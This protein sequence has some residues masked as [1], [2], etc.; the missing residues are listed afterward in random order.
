MARVF[1]L[2]D[3]LIEIHQSLG[4]ERPQSVYLTQLRSMD[5]RQEKYAELTNKLTKD[6][7]EAL[8]LDASATDSAI[9]NMEEFA[10]FNMELAAHTWTFDASPQQVL[11]H[12]LAYDYVPALARRLAF[13]TLVGVE[14]DRPIDA[15]MPGGKFWF[16]PDMS[17]AD[18]ATLPMRHVL[19]WLLDLLGADSHTRAFATEENADSLVRKLQN[20]RLNGT[21]PKSAKEIAETFPDSLVL[22]FK[23]ALLLDEHQDPE[24]CFEQTCLFVQSKGLTAEALQ[25]EIPRSKTELEVILSGQADADEKKRFVTL[26]ARRYAAPRMA[27]IRQRLLVGRM[28]QDGY[29]RLMKFLCPDVEPTSTNPAENKLIQ[30]LGLF[31]TVYDLTIRAWQENDSEEDQ[32]AWFT[33]NL[34]FIYRFDVLLSINPTKPG[35][36]F[37]PLVAK[38]LSKKFELL[39]SDAAIQDIVIYNES[40][41]PTMLSNIKKAWGSHIEKFGKIKKAIAQI[42]L[43]KSPWHLM[44]KENDYEVIHQIAKESNDY[45][46]RSM[47]IARLKELAINN[48][49]KAKYF[50][51]ALRQ[52]LDDVENY[53]KDVQTGV[54]TLLCEARPLLTTCWQAPILH[55]K[56]KHALMQNKFEEAYEYLENAFEAC[57]EYSVG[58]L[59][60]EIA[61]DY[62]SVSIKLHGLNIK[63]QEKLY[64][65]MLHFGGPNFTAESLPETAVYCERFFWERLYKPYPG[66][67][68]ENDPMNED[69]RIAN[70]LIRTATSNDNT[71]LR[72]FL[73]QTPQYKKQRLFGIKNDSFLLLLIKLLIQHKS[74]AKQQR[75][76]EDKCT[77]N[78]YQSI[79]YII[80]DCSNQ[81]KL[82]DFKG[83]IP[84]MLAANA[85]EYELL[86]LLLPKSDLS[87]QD[88]K[89][90]T[91]LHA[92]VASRSRRCVQAV[93]D[94]IGN[95]SKVIKD[96]EEHNALHTAVRFGEPSVI[97]LLSDEYP[98][99]VIQQNAYGQKP[100]DLARDILQDVRQWR[101]TM[102]QMGRETGSQS[103][104][105]EIVR[106]LEASE[107]ELV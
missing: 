23:G 46:V 98:S 25:H 36:S 20:W 21:V 22:N 41:L 86:K 37:A 62:W 94:V 100:L 73:S 32:D 49:Q 85:G 76:S 64:L 77:R 11:W 38:N 27:L 43:E 31:Q 75:T 59:R 65:N 74:N 99:L 72:Q 87:A 47:A 80:S 89:G 52:L 14:H 18:R 63:K 82:A 10:A 51:F 28:M 91:V 60:A 104:F 7:C 44:Q 6:I 12:L 68:H 90:R 2:A 78:L 54:E 9:D 105:E 4:L 56:G 66:I 61:R 39:I 58:P 42:K 107:L 30:L 103:D 53:P 69:I 55:L 95:V 13:W 79:K 15:G 101:T 40:V 19:D 1:T 84:A 96:H 57:Q 48:H 102:H 8:Q 5:I 97:K 45:K 33:E 3:A 26:M 16:L 35:Q 81:A 88:Y 34:P 83:Q 67:V 93:L 50:L 17:T 71:H 106:L 24:H 92:A 70:M 29:L